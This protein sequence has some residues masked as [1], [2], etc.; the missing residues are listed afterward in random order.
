MEVNVW[1]NNDVRHDPRW[2]LC[3]DIQAKRAVLVIPKATNVTFD[4]LLARQLSIQNFL[5]H[6]PYLFQVMQQ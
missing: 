2:F 5:P 3:L 6:Y 1:S 4:L